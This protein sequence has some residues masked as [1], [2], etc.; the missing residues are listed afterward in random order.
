MLL[1]LCFQS[2]QLTCSFDCELRSCR[3]KRATETHQGQCC[4]FDNIW[5]NLQGKK[6]FI[7]LSLMLTESIQKMAS[8]SAVSSEGSG[9]VLLRGDERSG[10]C[11]LWADPGHS[12]QDGA[13]CSTL[14]LWSGAACVLVFLRSPP[15]C[16]VFPH[17]SL[18]SGQLGFCFLKMVVSQGEQFQ[19]VK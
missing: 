6:G 9:C 1:A 3:S 4:D 12:W 2:A 18:G 14:L 19:C 7:F 8:C 17:E 16:W 10:S 13:V 11:G 5:L 15:V